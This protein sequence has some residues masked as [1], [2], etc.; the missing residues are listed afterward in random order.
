MVIPGLSNWSKSTIL[1]AP[2]TRTCDTWRVR[3]FSGPC[4]LRNLPPLLRHCPALSARVAL[5]GSR[6]GKSILSP[7][8]DR[9]GGCSGNIHTVDRTTTHLSES[10]RDR[11]D[12]P[13]LR[14][15][16]GAVASFETARGREVWSCNEAAS[17]LRGFDADSLT[18]RCSAAARRMANWGG[19]HTMIR[20][21]RKFYTTCRSRDS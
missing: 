21:A 15:L 3:T 14:A 13:D 2:V 19:I 10:L 1:C 4:G 6:S 16:A 9:C 20:R 5:P 7:R 18:S 12:D 17:A 8:L 11:P